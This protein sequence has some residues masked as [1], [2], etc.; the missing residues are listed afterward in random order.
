MVPE[1]QLDQPG[2]KHDTEGGWMTCLRRWN[3]LLLRNEIKK[4]E[5]TEIEKSLS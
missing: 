4:V 3:E 1:S 5:T 2:V